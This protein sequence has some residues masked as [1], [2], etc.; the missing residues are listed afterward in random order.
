MFMRKKNKNTIKN[1]TNTIKN[2]TNILDINNKNNELCSICLDNLYNNESIIKL[3]CGHKFHYKCIEQVKNN[4]CPYCREK[5]IKED[6]C[7]DNHNFNTYFYVS[8]R[9]KDGT[10][11]YCNLKTY[12]VL[13]KT[14][15]L[16]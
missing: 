6:I 14:K 2:S 13:L 8:N 16:N 15:I 5:I 9:K 11:L 1:L 12:K 10:C 7:S 4:K 3:N